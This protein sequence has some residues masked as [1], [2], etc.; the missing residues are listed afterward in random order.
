MLPR[1]TPGISSREHWIHHVQLKYAEP[2]HENHPF[3]NPIAP[4]FR[5]HR[6]QQQTK[7][8]QQYKRKRD[9]VKRR[10]PAQSQR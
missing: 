1:A 8:K 7:L 2:E 4:V 5:V 10:A 3:S 6:Q 9:L